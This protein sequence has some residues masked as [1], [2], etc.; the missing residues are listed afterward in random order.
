MLLG[1][2]AMSPA[3]AA[4]IVGVSVRSA[5]I[6][7]SIC[8]SEKPTDTVR[9]SEVARPSEVRCTRS[10]PGA[11]RGWWLVRNGPAYTPGDVDSQYTL[12]GLPFTAWLAV[13]RPST[14]A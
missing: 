6:G 11:N 5:R 1:P 7:Q 10:P 3:A 8:P 9:V 4:V 12:R 14:V 13:N 2:Q